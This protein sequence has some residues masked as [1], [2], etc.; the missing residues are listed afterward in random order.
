[1][2][3]QRRWGE[4]RVSPT[5]TVGL[6]TGVVVDPHRF[7][8][9]WIPTRRRVEAGLGWRGVI[10][11]TG[12]TDLD[13]LNVDDTRRRFADHRLPVDHH[14]RWFHIDNPG[15]AVHRTAVVPV[16]HRRWCTVPGTDA[17]VHPNMVRPGSWRKERQ[18][19]DQGNEKPERFHGRPFQ[20]DLKQEQDTACN[21][22]QIA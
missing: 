10:H 4:R 8:G 9:A 13:R 18:A 11:D 22:T 16:H 21:I 7:I 1:M 20:K 14:R 6:P 15:L 19:D 5:E 17:H 2:E 12:F 3:Q